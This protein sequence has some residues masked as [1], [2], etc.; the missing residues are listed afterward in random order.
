MFTLS[1]VNANLYLVL[2]SVSIV[3]SYLVVRRG[4]VGAPG[5]IIVASMTNSLFAFLYAIARGNGFAQAVVSSMAVGILFA[6]VTG[7]VS[8]SFRYR[9]L[10]VAVTYPPAQVEIASQ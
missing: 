3:V 6:V 5:T 10:H 9:S 1:N 4:Y 7:V 8:A 2:F